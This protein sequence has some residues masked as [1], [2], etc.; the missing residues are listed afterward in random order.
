MGTGARCNNQP[1]P[2]AAGVVLAMGATQLAMLS[3]LPVFAD[4]GVTNTPSIFGEAGPEM[5]VP[6][7]G[8]AGQKAMSL[9]SDNLISRI[10]QRIG[11]S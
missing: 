3:G 4:G 10:Q 1:G 9:L 11:Y 5:A 8:N 2:I 7:S 6:L